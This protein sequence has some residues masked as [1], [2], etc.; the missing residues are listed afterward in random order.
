MNDRYRTSNATVSGVT[1]CL[2]L[3]ALR[4]FITLQ[5]LPRAASSARS[6]A[7]LS[8]GVS[9]RIASALASALACGLYW[10]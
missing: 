8:W 4:R 1:V 10:G 2:T 9:R 3:S 7:A 6:R 5:N